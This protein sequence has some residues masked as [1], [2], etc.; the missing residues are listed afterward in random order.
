MPETL[1]AEFQLVEALLTRAL[2][3]I[4]TGDCR[5]AALV[6]DEPALWPGYHLPKLVVRDAV[7]APN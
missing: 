1:L 2:E 4:V 3:I 5:V 6:A 7:R